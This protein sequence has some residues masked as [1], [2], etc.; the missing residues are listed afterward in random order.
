MLLA[1]LCVHGTLASISSPET[2]WK[3]AAF[4]ILAKDFFSLLSGLL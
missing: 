1:A 4:L 3:R 2:A